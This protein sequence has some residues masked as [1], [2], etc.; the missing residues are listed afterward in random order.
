[1]DPLHSLDL[2]DQ[3]LC[4]LLVVVRREQPAQAQHAVV[5]LAGNAAQSK[6]RGAAE[7]SLCLRFDTARGE[8]GFRSG[9]R[10]RLGLEHGDSPEVRRTNPCCSMA[11][12]RLRQRETECKSIVVR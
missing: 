3:L 10:R 6:R 8:E 4:P 12:S 1:F 5:K 9:R 11:M 7:P 2:L